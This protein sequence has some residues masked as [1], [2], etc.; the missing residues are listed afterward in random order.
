MPSSLSAVLA[1]LLGPAASSPVP[2]I[3]LLRSPSSDLSLAGVTTVALDDDLD[4]F[5][6]V[7]VLYDAE[8]AVDKVQELACLHPDAA[9]RV[10]AV[11]VD[12]NSVQSALR[13]K[14]ILRIAV[15]VKARCREAEHAKIAVKEFTTEKELVELLES[16]VREVER[17][18]FEKEMD[19]A[20]IL[21]D[22]QRKKLEK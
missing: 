14:M 10:R 3:A 21:A 4:A 2:R 18:Y 6:A 5:D 13:A 17:D 11:L 15:E 8:S 7:V 19:K 12:M 1:A 9:S 16:I 20:R 22:E